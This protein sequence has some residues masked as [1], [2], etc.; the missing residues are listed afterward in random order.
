[1]SVEKIQIID[2]RNT[3]TLKGTYLLKNEGTMLRSRGKFTAWGQGVQMMGLVMQRLQEEATK[4]NMP[5]VDEYIAVNDASI[6]LIKQ[7]TEYSRTGDDGKGH[8]V[9][10][11]RYEP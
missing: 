1:M 4:R 5:I 8:P 11:R 3:V 2:R 10:T 9:Y 6:N 7:F